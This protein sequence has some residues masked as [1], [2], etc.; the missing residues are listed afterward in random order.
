MI[1]FRIFFYVKNPFRPYRSFCKSYL[2]KH[3]STERMPQRKDRER[4]MQ[5]SGPK[6]EG[7]RTLSF[8]QLLLNLIKEF[9]VKTDNSTEQNILDLCPLTSDY[10]VDCVFCWSIEQ[11]WSEVHTVTF[12]PKISLTVESYFRDHLYPVF[13][14]CWLRNQG[15][16]RPDNMSTD[17]ILLANIFE[18]KI[19]WPL[20][21]TDLKCTG[22]LI[23]R[24]LTKSSVNVFFLMIFFNNIFSVVFLIVG[25]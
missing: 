4:N 13:S 14:F 16:T 20:N 9:E 7:K 3:E 24:V 22:P 5:I 11:D 21:N 6:A 2:H 18:V 8:W 1:Y 10:D 12:H 19:G 15:S 17:L 25:I 23:C